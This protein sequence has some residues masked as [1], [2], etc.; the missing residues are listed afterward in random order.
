M[1]THTVSKNDIERKW[2][3]VDANDIRLGKLASTVAQLLIGKGKVNFVKNLN[4]GDCVI[5][6]NA[7]K[8]SVSANK[9]EKKIYYK[10]TGYVGHLKEETLGHLL[11]RKPEDVIIKAISGMLPKNKLRSRFLK[12]L[13][14]Y[15]GTEHK[16]EA[17]K[18]VKF[19]IR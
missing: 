2:Y 1:K 6:I 14:V 10:H 9:K 15:A 13:H 12:N 8:I 18:P 19:E 5:V 4:M 7:E 3:I 17:Q 16:Y 11:K